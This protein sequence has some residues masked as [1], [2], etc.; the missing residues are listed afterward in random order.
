M[1]K[2]KIT[3]HAFIKERLRER[4]GRMAAGDRLPSELAL[5]EEYSVSR[6]TANKVVNCLVDE[7]ML[8][9]IKGSGTYVRSPGAGRQPA[10]FLLPC[11]ECFIYDCTYNL[12][13]Q[14]CGALREAARS[15]REIKGVPASKV[16]NP[17]KIDWGEFSAF[18]AETMVVV[19]SFWFKEL[20]PLLRERRCRTVFCDTAS[21]TGQQYPDFLA[22]WLVMRVDVQKA[23]ADAV[24]HL[25]ASGRR[26]IAYVFDSYPMDDPLNL[27]YRDG[28][29]RANL[30]FDP[31][32]FIY[33][34]NSDQMYDRLLG[35]AAAFDALVISDFARVREVMGLLRQAGRKI[36]G[37]VA[38]LVFGDHE[39][40][41]GY[42]PP[43]SAVSLPYFRIG[44]AIGEALAEGIAPGVVEFEATILD[45]ESS[46]PGAG[47]GPDGEGASALADGGQ[48]TF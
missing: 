11:P 7:G 27:G 48:F 13:L 20:F 44:Q 38:V 8:Y 46:L 12:R 18:D 34:G 4:I 29:A 25:A 5:C 10:R 16:N 15:G 3:A 24:V 43:L 19:N 17:D 22:D 28:L 21:R 39:R 23:M 26:R 6:M 35:G 37:D 2:G 14:L 9:R 32:L 45:R 1:A 41:R 31:G 47:A 42:D 40:L 36:P 30:P 33:S